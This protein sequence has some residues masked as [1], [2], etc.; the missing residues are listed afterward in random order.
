MKEIVINQNHFTCQ[1]FDERG[2]NSPYA[3]LHNYFY[4]TYLSKFF[5]C[6]SE[7]CW[8]TLNRCLVNTFPPKKVLK[9]LSIS[10]F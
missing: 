10:L 9:Q 5:C 3:D 6:T 4:E 1:N 7:D 8:L 2:L